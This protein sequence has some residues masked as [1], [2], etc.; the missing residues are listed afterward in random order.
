[1]ITYSPIGES[2]GSKCICVIHV[3]PKDKKLNYLDI[4]KD[5]KTTLITLRPMLDGVPWIY[6]C[7]NAINYKPKSSGVAIVGDTTGNDMDMIR[8]ISRQDIHIYYI[9]RKYAECFEK[10]GNVIQYNNV[11]A[12][13]MMDIIS[14]SDYLL[15]PKKVDSKYT[16]KLISGGIPLAI[17]LLTPIISTR[18]LIDACGISDVSV[19]YKNGMKIRKSEIDMNAERNKCITYTR[20]VLN[21]LTE[22][23]IPRQVEQ[24]PI[25]IHFMW[26]SKDMR[27][28]NVPEK[29]HMHLRTWKIRNPNAN[30]MIWNDDSVRNVIKQHF[31][32]YLTFYDTLEPV[33]CR[34]DWVRFIIVYLYGGLYADL[35][36]YCCKA[37]NGLITSD[38]L[39]YREAP[40]HEKDGLHLYNGFFY[41]I[42]KHPMLKGWIDYIVKN[43]KS[44]V[45]KKDV[46]RTTGP[47]GLYNFYRMSGYDIH[48]GNFCD[49]MPYTDS[50]KISRQCKTS[51]FYTYTKWNEGS[52]WGT[53]SETRFNPFII[54][55]L[56]ILL[57]VVICIHIL[58]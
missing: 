38:T 24:P 11:D 40:E 31:P 16:Y 54:I 17:S 56:V 34:C 37:I 35:D 45:D 14:N 18:E 15:V 48:I 23:Y 50:G 1:M 30:I 20:N 55:I 26:L 13:V 8:E 47:I 32:K 5:T 6:G 7:Y 41:S 53:K 52:N 33:I 39:F 2:M 46:V 25:N 27:R 12:N 51:D 29:Y 42:P 22:K 49:I 9:G 21:G 57:I 36:F 44:P 10:M 4:P 19:P 3:D 58:I 28:V 43:V